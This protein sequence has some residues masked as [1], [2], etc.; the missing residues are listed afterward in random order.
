MMVITILVFAFGFLVYR[1]VDLHQN[2]LTQASMGPRAEQSAGSSGEETQRLDRDA[3]NA[4]LDLQNTIA[5]FDAPRRNSQGD[6]AVPGDTSDG[7]E[8]A[9]L[10][11]LDLN[12]PRSGAGIAEFG[13]A[14]IDVDSNEPALLPQELEEAGQLGPGAFAEEAVSFAAPD[15][16][17]IGS[18]RTA[19]DRVGDDAVVD[20]FGQPFAPG[21]S[22]AVVEAEP[23][24]SIA[25][26][27][28]FAAA[29]EASSPS[30]RAEE[31]RDAS[32]SLEIPAFD[33]LDSSAD[34][35][36]D[37]AGFP[38]VGRSTESVNAAPEA[39]FGNGVR[40]ADE[41][42]FDGVDLPPLAEVPPGVDP[43]FDLIAAAE[44]NAPD[45]TRSLPV[46][47]SGVEPFPVPAANARLFGDEVPGDQQPGG[48]ESS[49][50]L[51]A[52]A[53]PRA[54]K[55]DDEEF[56]PSLDV[57]PVQNRQL[58]GSES[59]FNFDAPASSEQ[60]AEPVFGALDPMD[61][62]PRDSG[63]EF[64][65]ATGSPP[66]SGEFEDLPF[67][68]VPDI[69]APGSPRTSSPQTTQVPPGGFDLTPANSIGSGFS[70]ASGTA[71]RR[72]VQPGTRFNLAG[73]NYQKDRDQKPAADIPCDVLEVTEG[74]NYWT[75]SKK[76]Y[77]T[78]RYFSALAVFNQNRIPDPRKMR[79]GMKILVPTAEVLEERYPELFD[80]LQP[81]T[82]Q[83]AEFLV[84]ENGQPA[85]RVGERET[86]SEISER[87]LG[88]SSRWIEIYRLNRQTLKDPNRLKPGM[89]LLL[90]DDAVEVNVNP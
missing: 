47:V 15:Q 33:E 52:M 61:E 11:M 19:V 71:P 32:V 13:T 51:I 7:V 3:E 48:A 38:S 55:G 46:H 73:Y 79:P 17:T 29:A 6:D 86:L 18:S 9:D 2:G 78:I 49:D 28:T 22:P 68:P 67:Q 82:V 5:E 69:L 35:G 59:D 44:L 21:G 56:L 42:S 62:L 31:S 80:D 34:Q 27:P 37:Q 76:A 70:G 90:P 20:V 66:G 8:H 54:G 50:M 65:P 45:A 57:A 10:R 14:T 81:K 43:E 74:D 63:N 72:V 75:L 24:V 23:A 26:D 1:K 85:Y 40:V 84:L 39:E 36:R 53:E 64:A 25:S 60:D 30:I 83:P 77:G 58:A 12:E 88:R 41:S 89:I 87:L 16:K 4:V